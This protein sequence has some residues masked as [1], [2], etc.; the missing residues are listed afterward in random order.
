MA[1]SL[2]WAAKLIIYSL[3]SGLEIKGK[4][5]TQHEDFCT[6]SSSYNSKGGF[7]GGDIYMKNVEFYADQIC[8]GVAYLIQPEMHIL[9]GEKVA[10]SGI[11]GC[12][13][14]PPEWAS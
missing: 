5:F 10:L 13:I 12:Q 3:S 2:Y 6:K 9:G 8:R 7:E 4:S 14:L 1:H 11:Y